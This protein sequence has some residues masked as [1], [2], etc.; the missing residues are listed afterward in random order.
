MY[1]PAWYPR[2]AFGSHPGFAMLRSSFAVGPKLSAQLGDC[3]LLAGG[4][5]GRTN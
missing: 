1:G 3:L 4:G 2:E 5:D